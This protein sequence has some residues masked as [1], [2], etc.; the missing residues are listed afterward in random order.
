MK[1]GRNKRC[2]KNA[3]NQTP[4]QVG[5]VFLKIKFKALCHVIISHA[6]SYD[7]KVYALFQESVKSSPGYNLTCLFSPF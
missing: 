4:I 1:T 5:V 7:L 2:T 3:R 6:L